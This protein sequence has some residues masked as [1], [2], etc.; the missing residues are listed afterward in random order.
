MTTQ[1]I[2][3]QM[4]VVWTRPSGPS[5]PYRW[6]D[7]KNANTDPNW[8]KSNVIY[9]WIKNSTGQVAVVGE[10]DRTLSQRV[11][12]YISAS[13]ES[14]AGQTNKRVHREQQELDRAGDFLYIE[15]TDAVPGYDLRDKRQRRLAES[16]L[17]GVTQP[18]LP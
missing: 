15:F 13:P 2:D 7:P 5:G 17:I 9:R 10:T 4:T 14:Q 3:I 18:Y 1:Q 12:N 11:N 8:Q 6:G 16:L